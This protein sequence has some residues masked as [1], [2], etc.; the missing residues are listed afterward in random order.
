MDIYTARPGLDLNVRVPRRQQHAGV[1]LVSQRPGAV[2][3]CDEIEDVMVLVQAALDLDGGTIVMAVQPFTLVALVADEVPG[4]ENERVLGN[5]YL[6][7]ITHGRPR[8]TKEK[9]MVTVS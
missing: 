8:Q 5:P 7:A 6:E 2:F 9:G 4:A 3:Q 1:Q